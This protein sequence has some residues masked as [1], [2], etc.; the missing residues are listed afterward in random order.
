VSSVFST[1]AFVPKYVHIKEILILFSFVLLNTRLFIMY[2]FKAELFNSIV[3]EN[4]V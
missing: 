2:Q 4:I 1:L 3:N